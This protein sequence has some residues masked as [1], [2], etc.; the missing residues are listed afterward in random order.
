MEK[1]KEFFKRWCTEINFEREK[2]V[3]R[4]WEAKGL[5]E[6]VMGKWGGICQISDRI[7]EGA[8]ARKFHSCH[9]VE[10][11]VAQGILCKEEWGLESLRS[12]DCRC[13]MRLNWNTEFFWL[14]RGQ[15]WSKMEGKKGF[16]GE[17]NWPGGCVCARCQ[18]VHPVKMHQG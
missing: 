4:I 3:M 6:G 12:K 7:R 1:K 14:W 17:D 15:K 10:V 9:T 5:R 13:R 2:W 16:T 8:Q 11:R 18:W